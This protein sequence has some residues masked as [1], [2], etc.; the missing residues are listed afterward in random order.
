M[1]RCCISATTQKND[2]IAPL[3]GAIATI[4]TIVPSAFQFEFKYKSLN[5]K[6]II[7]NSHII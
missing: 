5:L 1:G 4:I 3:G 7:L 2:E 6:A